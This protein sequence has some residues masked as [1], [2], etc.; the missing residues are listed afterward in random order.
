MPMQIEAIAEPETPSNE[1]MYPPI[2]TPETA[3]LAVLYSDN[4]KVLAHTGR[5]FHG[6]CACAGF[7]GEETGITNV[8]DEPGF[9]FFHTGKP[10][11][12]KCWETGV[13]D[14][15]GIDG[16]FRKAT[17]ED[18]DAAGLECQLDLSGWRKA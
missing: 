2:G 6:T 9:Y 10:W 4:Y 8:P 15:F 7:D 18:F 14:D 11:A 13:A 12:H 17:P 1:D 3:L 16:E 5:Y